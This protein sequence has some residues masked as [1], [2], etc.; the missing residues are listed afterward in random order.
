MAAEIRKISNEVKRIV[1]KTTE[2]SGLVDPSTRANVITKHAENVN[3]AADLVVKEKFEADKE[4]VNDMTMRLYTPQLDLYRNHALEKHE[5]K[6][7]P[8]HCV[9]FSMK[10]GGSPNFSLLTRNSFLNDP[11]APNFIGRLP[12]Q[13]FDDSHNT[14]QIHCDF[15]TTG[16][17]MENKAFYAVKMVNNTKKRYAFFVN[18]QAGEQ[19]QVANKDRNS[20]EYGKSHFDIGDSVMVMKLP[21][22]DVYLTSSEGIK[23]RYAIPGR[24][25]FESND[26]VQFNISPETF[27]GIELVYNVYIIFIEK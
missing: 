21:E 9:L 7:S 13:S 4:S 25:I 6:K 12:H 3:R 10:T 23:F 26:K 27:N 15:K 1:A 11:S 22:D 16:Q 18:H 17:S 14:I 2:F 20:I 8:F 24:D 19:E 5:I